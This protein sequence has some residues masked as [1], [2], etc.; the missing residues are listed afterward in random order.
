MSVASLDHSRIIA[1]GSAK[2]IV[3][4]GQSLL[5]SR[6]SFAL[7]AAAS[8]CNAASGGVAGSSAVIA[9][10]SS[11]TAANVDV[12]ITAAGA[13]GATAFKLCVRLGSGAAD[14]FFDLATANAGD[15]TVVTPSGFVPGAVPV[16]GAA[17]TGVLTLSGNGLDVADEVIFVATGTACT[18]TALAPAAGAPTAVFSAAVT[19]GTDHSYDVDTSGP[20]TPGAYKMCVRPGNNAAPQQFGEVV[21]S[22][23][24]TVGLCLA[25]AA[26]FLSSF[27][28][29]CACVC[30][31]CVAEACGCAGHS[32][33]HRCGPL[34]A[35]G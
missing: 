6:D 31:C 23:T 35:G 34:Q 25:L 30:V 7:I 33:H 26:V 12:S 15:V 17:L 5:A 32:G 20:A 1:D 8:S 16:Q 18:G 22:P 27:F 19:P 24:L 14:L 10:G 13:G 11:A 21:G 28:C 4:S 9:G 2:R 3:V 29:V